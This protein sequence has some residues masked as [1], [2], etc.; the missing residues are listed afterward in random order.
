MPPAKKNLIISFVLAL[1]IVVMASLPARAQGQLPP[2][3][4]VVVLVDCSTS[5]QPYIQPIKGILNRFVSGSRKGDSFTCY[6]FSKSPILVAKKKIKRAGDIGQL[7]TQLQSIRTRD[8]L[9]NYA[10]ALERAMEEITASYNERPKNERVLIL[11]TDGRRHADDPKS[12]RKALERLLARYSRIKARED[13][14]F[15]CFFIGDSP[16]EDLQNYLNAVGV[17]STTWPR[18]PGQLD[19]L[20]IADVYILDSTVSL[21]HIPDVR[22]D[23]T[24]SITFSPRRPPVDTTLIKLETRTDFGEATLD[25][26]FSVT[27]TYVEC[28]KQE[29]SEKFNLE[30]RGFGKGSYSGAFTFRPNQPRAL[31]LYPRTIDFDFSISGGLRVNIPGSLV[32]GPTGLRG[33]Y[34]EKKQISITPTRAGLPGS[35]KAVSVSVDMEVP[36]GVEVTLTKTMTPDA[37]DI[38]VAVV[39]DQSLSAR[40]AGRYEGKIVITSQKG[41]HLSDQEI[42]IAVDISEKQSASGGSLLYVA[43][44]TVICIGVI[45]LI[46]FYARGGRQ[47]ITEYFSQSKSP[48]GKLV[49]TYD[50]TR[51]TGANIN[52]D[53]LSEVHGANE[54]TVGVGPGNHVE[55]SHFSMVGKEYIFSGQKEGEEVLTVVKAGQGKDEVVINEM[56]HTGEV[57]LRHLND[58]KLG[59]F[60]FRY[61]MS[62]PM[63]QVVLYHLN[64]EVRQGWLRSWNVKAE[65]FHFLLRDDPK[66]EIYVRYY[67]LKAV[68]FVR[69]FEGELCERHLSLIAPRSGHRVRIFF[70]D[71]EELT[72][73][74]LNWEDPRDRFYFFPDS[75][76]DNV[77]LFLVDN[78]AVSNVALLAED[79][80][81]AMRAKRLLRTL[82]E[83]TSRQVGG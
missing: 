7:R 40:A 31:L 79:E 56:S 19:K 65:G 4:D 21:G 38:E 83:E 82:L 60:E 63:R 14:S 77:L 45:A 41:W 80:K 30:T 64:G 74:I 46:L 3:Q 22:A 72:G 25:R 35:A 75:M 78:N 47:G 70:S 61:E 39:R 23:E 26:H 1:I 6:Q 12:E 34:G 58:L 9:T 37:I 69:D 44:I 2:P 81:G 17:Y 53:R 29:W 67:D 43:V 54:I 10:T 57:V 32:F 28:Q 18:N 49:L 5:A 24:F 66:K 71:K 8:K 52:L 50:P 36:E 11:I 55:L 16:A 42:P 59:S 62:R 48:V 15:Y 76:G 73:Y 13:F 20:T 51:G 33:R 68:A 27:P